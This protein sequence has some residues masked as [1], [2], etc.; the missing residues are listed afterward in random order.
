MPR[1]RRK[2]VDAAIYHVYARGNARR[3][4]FCDDEDRARFLRRLLVVESATGA[5]HFA[6]CLMTNHLHLVVRPGESG[7]SHLMQR[8]LGSHAQWF[9]RRHGAVGH[10]FQDRYG[11]RPLETD[12]DILG[13]LRYVHRNPVEAGMV[14]RPAEWRWSS[15]A[16]HLKANPPDYLLHGAGFIRRMLSDRVADSIRMYRSL[17]ERGTGEELPD[18]DSACTAAEDPMEA[19]AASLEAPTPRPHD[20]EDIARAVEAERGLQAGDIRGP[21]RDRLVTSGR[22]AFCRIAVRER[23][24]RVRDV[25]QFLARGPSAVS[26]LSRE[27]ARDISIDGGRA[28]RQASHA[29]AQ[30]PATTEH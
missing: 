3:T 2:R 20:L 12:G 18:L 8:V 15:H 29:G 14:E 4:V 13:I 16:D 30:D 5:V 10:L 28:E 11:S 22:K 26:M 25:A 7:L 24:W 17:V 1:R 9:N 6:H 23:G 21:R 27:P 19:S